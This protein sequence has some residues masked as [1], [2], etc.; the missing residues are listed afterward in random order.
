MIVNDAAIDW[1]TL[2]SYERDFGKAVKSFVDEKVEIVTRQQSR[3]LGYA[4][5][6]AVSADGSIFLGQNISGHW[7]LTVSGQLADIIFRHHC[8]LYMQV[9]CTRM[10]VQVTI[11]EPIGWKQKSFADSVAESERFGAYSHIASESGETVYLGSRKS[12]AFV[13]VYEKEAE[14]EVKK[15]LR[16]EVEYKA[17]RSNGLYKRLR[18][19]ASIGGFLVD[20]IQRVANVYKPVEVFLP[21]LAGYPPNRVRLAR[22]MGNT[23]KWLLNQVFPAL[24]KALSGKNGQWVRDWLIAL[25]GLGG[26]HEPI[27]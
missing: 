19:G 27:A 13:R 21:C 20:S 3:M 9:R 1:L 17:D 11:P 16:Y 2:T 23:E 8:L 7:M 5:T 6:R 4:G 14:G 10:D 22:E 15:W 24:E 26:E 12:D 25:L 18:D